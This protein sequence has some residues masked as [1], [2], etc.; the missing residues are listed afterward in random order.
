M[1]HLNYL[2]LFC[3][4]LIS[5]SKTS[6]FVA[7]N[8]NNQLPQYS[9]SGRNIAGALFNDTTWRSNVYISVLSGTY[10]SGFWIIS[11]LS[12]DSTTIIF[13]GKLSYNSISFVDSLPSIPLNFFVVIKGLKIENQD[14]LFKLNNKT[15]NLDGNNNYVTLTYS[16]DNFRFLKNK[17]SLG[18][19]VFKKVQKNSSF[20]IGDGSPNNPIINPFIVSGLFNFTI[21]GTSNYDIKDGRF[22]MVAQWKTNL[23]IIQ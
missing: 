8:N 2:I 19:I 15:F 22:D 16:Y 13:N 4:V 12:G 6:T 17:E 7:D 9:E 3:I 14:S 11:S 20:T 5:C 10:I 21:N 18:N 1:K 23:I